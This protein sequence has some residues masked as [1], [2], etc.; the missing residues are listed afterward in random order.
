MCLNKCP[1]TKKQLKNKQIFMWCSSVVWWPKP[2]VTILWNFDKFNH[3]PWFQCN[4]IPHFLFLRPFFLSTASKCV[5]AERRLFSQFG[6]LLVILMNY[7]DMSMHKVI[8]NHATL[9]I[10]W[11]I[12][13]LSIN[14]NLYLNRCCPVYDAYLYVQF[15]L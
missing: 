11:I 5:R 3:L 7:I 8:V 14:C 1:P 2:I 12:T 15:Q 10:T 6:N 4:T 9:S 13:L